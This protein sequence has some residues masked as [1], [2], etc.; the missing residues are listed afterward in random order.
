MTRKPLIAFLLLGVAGLAHAQPSPPVPAASAGSNRALSPEARARA[1]VAAMTIEEKLAIIHGYF[2]PLARPSQ[3]IVMIPSAGHIPGI[4]RL[5]IPTLRESDASLGVANQIEQRKGDTATALPASLA[6]AATFNPALAYAGGAM[7]GAEARAKTFNILLA[8]GVNLTRDPW[9]GRNFEYLGED[10]LLA[11]V[12]AGEHIRGVQS[13]HIVSTIKHFALNSQETGRTVL[14]AR[15]DRA[16]LRESDLLA[17]QI[18]TEIGDPASVMCAYNKV[19]GDYACEN[20]WLLNQ[21]LKRDWG[22][23]GWVMSDWGAVHSTGKAALGG[24]DQES[25]QE[26]D[27]A[28]HFGK[29]FEEAVKAG[30]I[31]AARLDD[32]VERILHGVI[33]SGLMDDPVPESPRQIDYAAHADIAQRAAEEGIILLKNEGDL[34]PLAK[35]ARRIVLIGGHADVGVLSG[36][37]SSQVRSVGGAPVEIPLTKGAAASFAR[38]TWHASSPLKAI[39]ALVPQAEVSYVDGGDPRAAAEA[40]RRADLAIVFG[41]Q[42]QTEAQDPE[43]MRLPDNQDALI[44]AVATANRKTIV[45]L[46]TGG[47]VEMPWIAKVPALVQAWYPGQRGGEAMANILFG[48]VAPSGRLPITFPVRAGQAPRPEPAG[49]AELHAA[50]ARRDAGDKTNYGM[51]G[52][53]APFAVDYPEGAEV[54]YRWY[55]MK[56][57]KPLFPFGHGLTY[58]SFTYANLAVQDGVALT[59]SFDV[60]NAGSRAGADVPQLYVEAKGSAGIAA[61]RLA[62]F[63]KLSLSPGETRRV[64]MTVDPRLIARFEEGRG[65]RLDGGNYALAVGHHAGDAALKGVARLD[66]KSLKP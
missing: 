60:T 40:A 46:E 45:V 34:L 55:A 35:S 3:P 56:G 8:G 58:T 26:L 27:D 63:D 4:P 21:V 53:V 50:E 59:V 42:W 16:A 6:T 47:P 31:P 19:N 9:N 11:G 37:G 7:I 52:G 41:W 54:G 13:A 43:N 18:A 49:L 44:D 57:V 29:P 1:L 24:L 14:D 17:F 25:G 66:A 22:Y 36:G 51:T 15:I 5:G 48:D 65:W 32:M 38:M 2:P 33:A 62:G 64:T 61:W 39:R 28:I 12:M 23:R 10:P 20:D 30:R